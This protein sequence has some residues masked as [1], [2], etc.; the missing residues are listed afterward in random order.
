[1]VYQQPPHSYCDPKESYRS[2]LIE[3][4]NPKPLNVNWKPAMPDKRMGISTGISVLFGLRKP[5]VLKICINNR[6]YSKHSWKPREPSV[7]GTAKVPCLVIA[8]WVLRCGSC[9]KLLGTGIRESGRCDGEFFSK[10]RLHLPAIAGAAARSSSCFWKLAVEF[11][12]KRYV[13]QSQIIY[14]H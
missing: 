9:L 8:T 10:K 14:S 11:L 1:M 4:A 2:H 3:S 6:R 5:S 12:L 13:S 7:V